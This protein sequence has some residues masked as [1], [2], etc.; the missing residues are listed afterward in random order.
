MI[1]LL[2]R[3]SSAK[4]VKQGYR[5]STY[6][7]NINDKKYTC[8]SG[9]DLEGKHCFRDEYDDF[10]LRC[11]TRG[12]KLEG[13]ICITTSPM[14]KICEG[15][16][17]LINGMCHEKLSVLFNKICPEG[18]D[19]M[20]HQCEKSIKSAKVPV[21][22]GD[23]FELESGICV[24]TE[25]AEKLVEY[26]CPEGYDEGSK[27]CERSETYDCT[28]KQPSKEQLRSRHG[29]GPSHGKTAPRAKVAIIQQTCEKTEYANKERHERCPENF[30][31][32]LQSR[33]CAKRIVKEP[34]LDC[35]GQMV[36][37]ECIVVD[38]AKH[39]YGCPAGYKQHYGSCNKISKSV[40][41]EIC[42]IGFEDRGRCV[43]T[44]MPKKECSR[45]FELVRDRCVKRLEKPV[46]VEITRTCEG[47]GCENRQ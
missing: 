23:G 5:S 15:D 41:T 19:D 30:A 3:I 28:A 17:Q 2:L 38:T 26:M 7:A 42:S 44:T 39:Q 33:A 11:E 14:D 34:S 16:A 46:T 18:Y 1:G 22:Y 27:G 24:K 9:Y 6:A 29:N 32:D 21:C 12:S 25:F 45:G 31:V 37:G 4:P 43:E 40:P 36:G 47:K 8:P 35:M 20:G 10:Q 13:D